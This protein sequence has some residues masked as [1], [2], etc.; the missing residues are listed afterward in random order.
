ML[1]LI[2]LA[3]VPLASLAF[4]AQAGA[5]ASPPESALE[6]HWLWSHA[7]AV[8]AETTSEQSGYFSIVEGQNDRLYIGTAKYGVNAYL[9]EFDPRSNQMKVVV[10]AQQVIGAAATGFAAQSKIHTRNNVG[11][12]GTIY[13]GTKQGY[14]KAGEKPTDYPGGYPM[15]FNPQ[16]GRT[17]VFPIPIPHQGIISVAPDESRGIAY[18]STCAD[19]RPIESAHFLVLDLESGR[20]TDLIDSQHMYAFIVVD[21]RGRAYHPLRG[22][23]IARYDPDAKSLA[24]LEQTIDGKPPTAESFLAHPESHPINWEVSPDRKTLYAVAMSGNQL[25]AYDLAADAKVLRGRSLGPLVKGAKATDCRAMCVGPDGVVWAGVAATSAE[26]AQ[27]LRLVRYRPGDPAPLDLGAIAIGNPDYT[28]FLDGDGKPKPHHHG[29]EKLHDGTLIPK[30]VI[31]GICAAHDGTVYL[32]TL[33]PFTVHAIRIPKVAGLASV[34]HVNSHAEMILGRMLQTDSLDGKGR[35]PSVELASLYLDQTPAS[36]IGVRLARE[37]GMPVSDRPADALTLGTGKLAVDGVLLV[38]EH[39]DY[40]K[41]PTGQTVYPKLRLFKEILSVFDASNRVAPVFIDKHLA[42]NWTDA[43]WIYDEASKRKI[44]L[45][46][47]SSLP[48]L[49]RYPPADVRKGAKLDQ[50][51]VTSYHTLDAYGFHAVEVLQCLAE[52]RRG[53]ETGVRSVQCISGPAVWKAGAE[54]IYDRA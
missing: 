51:V 49:W 15:T 25:Y 13:F 43:K 27:L 47:G 16:T 7:C 26:G 24:T 29:V 1:R 48:G 41:S 40:P 50:I 10:D 38:A 11:A 18:L 3:I 33:Y 23:K 46:A 31:M 21:H 45:M 4:A 53:G 39:G 44:P 5:S 36:D 20:Y 22:G 32:T 37:R 28:T 34:Y 54:G 42:D 52:R 6:R 17:R 19:G 2:S 35:R 8:P 14:P 9:V 12:S 30:F